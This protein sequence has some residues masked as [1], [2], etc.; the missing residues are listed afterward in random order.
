MHRTVLGS[1]MPMIR[2]SKPCN[3]FY[4]GC[5]STRDN[6]MLNGRYLKLNVDRLWPERRDV[7]QMRKNVQNI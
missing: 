2:G 1:K 4:L 5:N 6:I 7:G 3:D